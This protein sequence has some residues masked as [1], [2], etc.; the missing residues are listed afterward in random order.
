MWGDANAD[1]P[2]YNLVL[3]WRIPEKIFSEM[4]NPT[5]GYLCLLQRFLTATNE[6]NAAIIDRFKVIAQVANEQDCGI[7]GVAKRLLHSHNATPVLTRPQHRLYQYEDGNIEM[8]VD[9]HTFSYVARRGIHLLLNK[10]ASLV[11]D[12]AFVLQGETE[13][14]L[15]ERVIGC[16]R[17]N[18]IDIDRALCLAV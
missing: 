14:E 13:E 15:P 10:T 2:G 17:L 1:G 9:L 8:V 3:Y 6:K 4:L 18:G 7:S 5:D 16:C 11:I 12:I